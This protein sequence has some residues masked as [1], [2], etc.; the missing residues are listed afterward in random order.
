MQRLERSRDH[1]YQGAACV[2]EAVQ[3]RRGRAPEIASVVPRE[4]LTADSAA[5]PQEAAPSPAENGEHIGSKDNEAAS[6]LVHEGA[7][8]PQQVDGHMFYDAQEGKEPL[9]VLSASCRRPRLVMTCYA[10]P[11]SAPECLSISHSSKDS[12]PLKQPTREAVGSHATSL[13]AMGTEALFLRSDSQQTGICCAEW[14]W[15]EEELAWEGSPET[16]D[17]VRADHAAAMEW[18]RQ[19]KQRGEDVSTISLENPPSASGAHAAPQVVL[20]AVH[21]VTPPIV[22]LHACIA[23][24]SIQAISKAFAIGNAQFPG[25]QWYLADAGSGRQHRTAIG[26]KF[27]ASYHKSHA[28]WDRF[29]DE[30][31]VRRLCY[32]TCINSAACALLRFLQCQAE[33]PWNRKCGYITDTLVSR[34]RLLVFCHQIWQCTL[35]RVARAH[36]GS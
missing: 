28:T 8:H 16:E 15:S 3:D 26:R 13:T 18:Y 25:P 31:K 27:S 19:A 11:S 35:R 36:E 21:D 2:Q 29:W 10:M 4:R 23:D 33:P 17:A 7:A 5:P 14:D 1:A 24:S 22:Y 20:H 32:L 34:S 6:A 12:C 30:H 9:G